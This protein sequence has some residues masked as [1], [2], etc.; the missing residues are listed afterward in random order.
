[1]YRKVNISEYRECKSKNAQIL[2]G[3][4]SDSPALPGSAWQAQTIVIHAGRWAQR[5]EN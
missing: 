3:H 5:L 1:M 4:F 2:G